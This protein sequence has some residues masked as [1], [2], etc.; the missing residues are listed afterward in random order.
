MLEMSVQT[1]R[2]YIFRQQSVNYVHSATL[3]NILAMFMMSFVFVI[4]LN[5]SE[6]VSVSFSFF[7]RRL[8]SDCDP[9]IKRRADALLIGVTSPQFCVC[10]KPRPGPAVYHYLFRV[11]SEWFEMRASISFIDFNRIVGSLA[12]VRITNTAVYNQI[13]QAKMLI[14]IRHLSMHYASFSK[15]NLIL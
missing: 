13:V 9:V 12:S 2:L 7:W 8:C 15:N 10:P 14:H 6:S 11:L 4:V 3:Y 5:G 1:I